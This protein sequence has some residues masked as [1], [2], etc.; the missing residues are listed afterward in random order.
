LLML[1][2]KQETELFFFY[3]FYFFYF[4]M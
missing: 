1:P 3:F 4:Y 2:A